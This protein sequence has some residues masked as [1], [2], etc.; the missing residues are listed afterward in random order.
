MSAMLYCI[1]V[2]NNGVG[3]YAEIG[4]SRHPHRDP[5]P[6]SLRESDVHLYSTF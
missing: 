4:Y 6:Q 3:A 1:L 2:M 5:H